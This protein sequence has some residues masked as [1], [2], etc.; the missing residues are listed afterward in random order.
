[1]S[2]NSLF[3]GN[4]VLFG[5]ARISVLSEDDGGLLIG[6][7]RSVLKGERAHYDPEH[8]H[9]EMVKLSAEDRSRLK[10]SL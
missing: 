10:E 3:R 4:D 1:M 9:V 6:I 5:G 2:K 8:V 7:T